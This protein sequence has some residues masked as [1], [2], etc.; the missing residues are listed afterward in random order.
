MSAAAL[1]RSHIQLL[2]VSTDQELLVSVW[3]SCVLSLL[4]VYLLPGVNAWVQ[5]NRYTDKKTMCSVTLSR[6]LIKLCKKDL[7]IL[8]IAL[9]FWIHRTFRILLLLKCVHIYAHKAQLFLPV[10]PI[11][12]NYYVLNLFLFFVLVTSKYH[13]SSHSQQKMERDP[14]CSFLSHQTLILMLPSWVPLYH[15]WALK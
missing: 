3:I 15:I 9:V 13:I 1:W 12:F 14:M 6:Y 7:N 10:T 11:F 4:P 8:W 5:I 2:L